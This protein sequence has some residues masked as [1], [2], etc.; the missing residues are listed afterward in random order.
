MSCE[1]HP[2]H[3]KTWT[4]GDQRPSILLE[5]TE[6]DETTPIDVTGWTVKVR[7]ERP[8]PAHTVLLKDAP[9]IDGPNGRVDTGPWLS[10][11]LVA[12][13]KQ[14]VKVEWYDTAN[15]LQTTEFFYI[16]VD[17]RPT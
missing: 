9:V 4:E 3:P 10:T 5:Y 1:T 2:T 15:E 8:R 14:L 16:D 6:D 11:D 13:Q 7:I 12:G 17:R